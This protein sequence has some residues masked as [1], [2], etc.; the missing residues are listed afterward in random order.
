MVRSE[1]NTESGVRR[2][3]MMFFRYDSI[4]FTFFLL[5]AHSLHFIPSAFTS[6][7]NV[8]EEKKLISNSSS[9]SKKISYIYFSRVLYFFIF[10]VLKIII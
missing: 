1:K 4:V 8:Q 2:R 6:L 10:I 3:Q 5:F 9:G 7:N